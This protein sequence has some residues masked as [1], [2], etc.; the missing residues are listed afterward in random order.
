M[1]KRAKNPPFVV[2]MLLCGY[3]LVLPSCR[4]KSSEHT[5][6]MQM[7]LSTEQNPDERKSEYA[8]PDSPNI[9]LSLKTNVSNKGDLRPAN[10]LEDLYQDKSEVRLINIIFPGTHNSATA[11]IFSD[12]DLAPGVSSFLYSSPGEFGYCRLGPLS[13]QGPLRSIKRWY[14]LP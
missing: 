6:S 7:A 12:S 2:P 11:A 1:I 10:W 4:I 9:E 3:A 5:S 8:S 13:E 14:S